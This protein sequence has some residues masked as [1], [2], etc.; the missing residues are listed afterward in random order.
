MSCEN[1]N[2]EIVAGVMKITINRPEKKNALTW[3]MY[4]ALS[5]N[6][7]RAELDNDVKVIF[8][9]GAGGSF[10]AGN[11]IGAFVDPP[12]A[13]KKAPSQRF[14]E[15]IAFARKPLVAAV[16]G[17]A[18]GIGTTML[19]HCDLVYAADNTRFSLPFVNLG[20]TPEAASS[21]LLPKLV[22]HQRASELLLFGEAFS[23]ETACDFGMVNHVF[24]QNTLHVEAFNE[25]EKLANKPDE[26]V[27]MTKALLKKGSEAITG[28]IIKEEL[29]LFAERMRSPEFATIIT[30]FLTSQKA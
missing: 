17:V 4:D 2:T 13:D 12:S 1:I 15:N 24:P 3:A 18:V 11:D 14:I 27:R 29:T 20:L 6:L 5:D 10:C 25:A 8:I 22:G 28:E 30:A 9:H 21:Y 16:D 19:L 23:A 26:S 7:E